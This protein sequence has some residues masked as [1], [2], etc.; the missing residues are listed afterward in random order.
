M[1]KYT[2]GS[3][4]GKATKPG[5]P[6][7]LLQNPLTVL[8]L[9]AGGSSSCCLLFSSLSSTCSEG[10]G[11]VGCYPWDSDPTQIAWLRI[12]WPLNIAFK[13]TLIQGFIATRNWASGD[14]LHLPPP[15]LTSRGRGANSVLLRAR[16]ISHRKWKVDSKSC[17]AL[18]GFSSLN[19]S[20]YRTNML[21]WESPGK[22]KV[23]GKLRTHYKTHL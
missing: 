6:K 18:S 8:Y 3:S 20:L 12:F 9:S 15:A 2:S 14:L 22:K 13:V 7:S 4:P 17:W 11:E 19:S 10:M 1:V 23:T 16:K 21:K 5:G